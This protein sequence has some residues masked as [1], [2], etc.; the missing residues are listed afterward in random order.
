MINLSKRDLI[1]RACNIYIST[2]DISSTA[3]ESY[4]EMEFN[5]D[6]IKT[7]N[8]DDEMKTKQNYNK[9]KLSLSENKIKFRED[10]QLHGIGPAPKGQN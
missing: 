2:T 7:F 5:I 4:Q 1:G 6:S 8:N 9:V 3:N 10:N